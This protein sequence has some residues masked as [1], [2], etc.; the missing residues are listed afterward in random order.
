MCIEADDWVKVV[1]KVDDILANERD[2]LHSLANYSRKVASQTYTSFCLLI[3]HS[4][5][6]VFNTSKSWQRTTLIPEFQ[7]SNMT[8]MSQ[9]SWQSILHGTY[10][11]SM[12]SEHILAPEA[13]RQR[14]T[15]FN[16]GFP[17][18]LLSTHVR[19]TSK[20]CFA[21]MHSE[22]PIESLVPRQSFVKQLQFKLVHSLLRRRY[23]FLLTSRFL[24][25]LPRRMLCFQSN[26]YM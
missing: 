3:S 9:R 10:P 22:D 2:L 7:P 6:T 14:S 11:S 4:S 1:D 13:L 12:L 19:L 17:M 16:T 24:Q 15:S 21:K 5:F 20:M 26:F 25:T 23:S 18:A 8:L